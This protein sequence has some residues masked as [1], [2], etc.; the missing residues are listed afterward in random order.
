MGWSSPVTICAAC[1]A[2]LAACAAAAPEV[3]ALLVE[4]TAPVRAELAR[5]VSSEFGGLPVTLADDALTASSDL[6]IERVPRRDA[7][8]RP[9]D[10]RELGR[11]EI[12]RLVLAAGH[13]VLVHDRN[14][15]RIPLPSAECRGR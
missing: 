1:P 8:G 15:R 6:V 10:G 5:S 11:P 3:S 4:P 9:I 14:G 7:E 13:C 12:F 2:L